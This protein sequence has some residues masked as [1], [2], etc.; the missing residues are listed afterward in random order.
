MTK[1]NYFGG[2]LYHP[3]SQQILLQQ[4]DLVWDLIDLKTLM[5]IKLPKTAIHFVYDYYH[6]ES[7]MKRSISYAEIPKL[8]EFPARGETI[9]A[10]ISLAKI[11]K[12]NLAAVTRQDIIVSK[13]VIESAQRLKS[14][15]KTIG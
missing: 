8:V 1:N 3:A 11:S 12:T 15:E 10:W 6:K 14:G 9:F 5:G 7:H 4:V 13:R 2:F